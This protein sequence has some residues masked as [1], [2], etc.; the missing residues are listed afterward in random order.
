MLS[1]ETPSLDE[2]SSIYL[3][4]RGRRSL[5]LLFPLIFQDD[6]NWT[7]LVKISL[8]YAMLFKQKKIKLD[9]VINAYSLILEAEAAE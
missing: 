3:K 7:G 1:T 6:F 8:F 9:M 5:V 4:Q 2:T